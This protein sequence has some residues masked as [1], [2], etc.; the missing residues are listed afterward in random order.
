MNM[1]T[2][3]M[4]T[5]NMTMAGRTRVGLGLVAWALSAMAGGCDRKAGDP[6]APG[7]AAG[8]APPD[9]VTVTF[10]YGSEKQDWITDVT[11]AFNASA[12]TVDGKPV[13]VTATPMGSG[14]CVDAVLSGRVHADLLS[15]ASSPFV[16]LGNAQSRAATGGDLLG[17]TRNLVLSPVVIATWKPMADAL[18]AGGKPAG[19]SDVLA[20]AGDPRG[21]A[22]RGHPEW[23]P[24]RFGHTHPEYSNSGLISVLAEC[25][26]GAGK[27]RD[28]T[29][30]DV[31][32][33]A[34]ATLLDTVER[35]VVHYGS[36]TGFFGKRMFAGGPAYLS[37]AVLYENM[38][39]AAN[40]PATNGPGGPDHPPLPVVA[41][42]PREGTFWSDHPA[43][44]VRRPWV[45]A[46]HAAA[47]AKYVDYLLAEPQQRKAMDHGFRPGDPSVPLSPAVFNAAHGVDPAQPTTTL[48]VPP[49]DVTA[50]AL[51]QWHR[52]KKHADVV[53]VLDTS[54]SMSEQGKMAAA[55]AGAAEMIGLLDDAD[56]MSL[57]PFSTRMNWAAQDV[58]LATGRAALAADVDR[59]YAD[60]DT[61]LYD[62]VDAAV[63]YLKAHP[64]PDRI[65]A[66]VVLTD[67][68]D[69]DSR[70][71]LDRVLA[72][73]RADE[74]GNGVR[75]FTIG[76]GSDADAAVLG[77]MA[78]QTRAKFY[79]GNPGNIR[80]VFRDI[81][82]FF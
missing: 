11:A 65:A 17:P 57:L 14:E 60:G 46:A 63:A 7:P 3:N 34:V 31:D 38:V 24:F 75:V 36:S 47:A 82:T 68:Q 67:G 51:R 52:H 45:D 10:L 1:T 72:D 48:A 5:M 62:T 43:G 74:S 37:A 19:W 78:D 35:S 30:A 2:T 70:L 18:G 76:Y 21:W 13:R 6:A 41:I 26:A 27:A 56:E 22:A 66:V 77:R 39:I 4:T 28:L 54:G 59:L 16:A 50:A 15:P 23:G 12:P 55:K 64:H 80:E 49:A 33:P 58:P 73:V 20:L 8:A 9:A 42:Y 53:L 40:D 32:S 61:A 81:A 71:S 29:V 69:T 25:Y 79:A 44:I